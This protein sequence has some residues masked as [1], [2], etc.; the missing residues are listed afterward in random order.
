MF[1]S[2]GVRAVEAAGMRADLLAAVGG[3]ERFENGFNWRTFS[4]A[5]RATQA[6]EDA[7]AASTDA[8]ATLYEAGADAAMVGDWLTGYISRWAEY[9]HAGARTSNWMITGPA[10]FPAERNRKRMEVESKRYDEYAAYRDGAAAWARRRLNS[11]AR[12]E[13]AASDEGG[14]KEKVANGVRVILN[15]TLDRVQIVFP[16]KPSADERA[17][18]KGE[19][20]R[21]APSLGAWQRQLTQNGVWASERVLAR[22]SATPHINPPE[23]S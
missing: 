9:Q 7:V 21:W 20:F 3:Y 19:A 10:R 16:D 18:L 1:G 22:L 23:A 6:I 4:P 11:A 14:H 12:A 17:I 8:V 13:V 15:K 5:K 2:G